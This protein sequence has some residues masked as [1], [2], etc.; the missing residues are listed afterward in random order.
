MAFHLGDDDT[1]GLSEMNLIPLIDI[2]LVLMIIF[3]VTA[4]VMN[5]TVPLDLPKTSAT[6][7]DLP[8][9]ILQISIN[10]DNELF[11]DEELLS[12]PQL[13]TRFAQAASDGLDPSI[14]LR[15]DK[16]TR[17]DMVAQ[18]LAAASNAGLTKVAF[19]NE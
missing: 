17:Y 15:A 12:L 13:Q 18:V 3:L 11:W 19:V 10:Q 9:D 7:N 8:D 6:I 14:H 4:T 16:D 5:P 2:M 1:Q